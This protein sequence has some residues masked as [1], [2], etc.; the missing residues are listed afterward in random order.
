LRNR[1]FK[2]IL[3]TS[4]LL[5]TL[6]ID[7]EEEIYDVMKFLREFEVHYLEVGLIE[8]FWVVVRKIDRNYLG[9]VEEGL[10]AIRETYKPLKP[11]VEAYIEAVKIY[12]LGHKDFIDALYYATALHTETKWLTIDRTFVN[13]L[14]KHNLKRDAVILPEE[15]V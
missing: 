10:K 5:P 4:F 1:K 7:V 8:A 2:V 15:L 12:D 9:T 14:K 11:P 6:G 3:D 13:F